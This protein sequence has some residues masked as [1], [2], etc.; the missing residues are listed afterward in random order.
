MGLIASFMPK[1]SE[2]FWGSGLH[3]HLSLL[4]S[5]QRNVF[6]DEAD[7]RLGLSQFAYY[8][9]GGVLHHTPALCAIVAPT[10]NSYKRLLPGR[11]NADAVVYGPGHRGAAVR[12]PEARDLGTRIEYRVPDPACNPYLAIACLI[13]A[14]LDGV[15]KKIDPGEFVNYDMSPLSDE[16]KIRRGLRLLPMNLNEALRNLEDDRKLRE[17]MGDL[18]FEEYLRNK[19]YEW[20][21]Y[22]DKVT[23]WERDHFL[24]LF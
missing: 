24:D 16:E 20:T 6:Y 13:E 9:I 2:N 17:V 4:D 11:W 1:I 14:G 12:I 8:F 19:W 15:N 10:V 7:K 23:Q 3:M 18:L 5:D 21:Q 22:R